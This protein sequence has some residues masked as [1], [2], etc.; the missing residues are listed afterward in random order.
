VNPRNARGEARSRR[1]YLCSIAVLFGVVALPVIAAI[2]IPAAGATNDNGG[3]G[4]GV[5]VRGPAH[6]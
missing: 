3:G 4:G 2:A 5:E 6:H 1:S